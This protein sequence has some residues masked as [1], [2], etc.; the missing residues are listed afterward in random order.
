[1]KLHFSRFEIG[2]KMLQRIAFV[3][4]SIIICNLRTAARGTNNGIAS[5]IFGGDVSF[6]G[7]VRRNVKLGKCTYNTSFEK[8]RPYL[9][10]AKHVVVNLENPVAEEVDSNVFPQHQEK[11]VGLFAE[12]GSLQ[13]MK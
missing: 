2:E 8:I 5:V 1:M 4:L 11:S 10:E 3:V 7:I 6:S 9:K 13:A 12:E